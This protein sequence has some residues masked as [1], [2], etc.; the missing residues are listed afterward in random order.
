MDFEGGG[1]RPIAGC[2]MERW[3]GR[4]GNG[5]IFCGYGDFGSLFCSLFLFYSFR[6]ISIHVKRF[7][8]CK[9]YAADESSATFG[10]GCSGISDLRN[11]DEVVTFLIKFRRYRGK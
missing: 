2:D 4:A 8:S 7:E 11:V 3:L 5:Y 10:S 9:N 1:Q 6:F